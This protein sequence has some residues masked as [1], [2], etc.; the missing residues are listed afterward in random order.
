MDVRLVGGAPW[1]LV[2]GHVP[3]NAEREQP[4]MSQLME[5]FW[6]FFHYL[7]VLYS[8]VQK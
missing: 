3:L 7:A 5:I 4:A 8:A 2:E 1:P 6:R